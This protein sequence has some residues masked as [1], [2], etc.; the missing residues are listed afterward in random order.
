MSAEVYRYEFGPEIPVEDVEAS[1]LLSLLAAES[2][3]GETEVQLAAAHFL[4]ADKR[5]CV[6][7]A[8]TPVGTDINKLFA[9]FLRREFGPAAFSVRRLA[10]ASAVP[11]AA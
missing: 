10:S 2:L 3:H 1:M 9:G 8:G 11:A 6:V 4:D 5:A 7:D